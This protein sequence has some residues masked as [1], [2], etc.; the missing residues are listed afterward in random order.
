[1]TTEWLKEMKQ[2]QQR[3]RELIDQI[4]VKRRIYLEEIEP[5]V[6]ELAK[7]RGMEPPPTVY[8]NGVKY[9]YVDGVKYVNRGQARK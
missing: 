9:V 3:E 8:L 7:I 4:E 2:R 6:E 5:L 1:M